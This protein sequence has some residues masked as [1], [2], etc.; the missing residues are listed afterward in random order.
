MLKTW[1]E[2][3]K[4][5]KGEKGKEIKSHN[6]PASRLGLR[7]FGHYFFASFPSYAWE[8]FNQPSLAWHSLSFP[9]ATWERVK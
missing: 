6:I 7:L 5:R 9:S 8:R 1:G 2:K 4:R 3:G